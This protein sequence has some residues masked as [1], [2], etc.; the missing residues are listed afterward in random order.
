VIDSADING[1]N[2]DKAVLVLQ[3]KTDGTYVVV[4]VEHGND[5]FIAGAITALDNQY[6]TL[7]IVEASANNITLVDGQFITVG[8]TVYKVDED[9]IVLRSYDNGVTIN[10]SDVASMMASDTAA[11]VYENAVIQF[12]IFKR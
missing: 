5:F 8:G 6:D 11:F 1:W 2:D 10:A 7:Q 3:E 12:I 9:A 4:D